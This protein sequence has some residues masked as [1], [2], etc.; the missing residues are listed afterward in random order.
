M[1]LPELTGLAAAGGTAGL[2][3]VRAVRQQRMCAD[4]RWKALMLPRR[5]DGDAVVS[6]LRSLSGLVSSPLIVIAGSGAVVL[7]VG[8]EDSEIIHRIAVPSAWEDSVLGQLRAAMPGVHI[9]ES[10][11]RPHVAA[12]V[13]LRRRGRAPLRDD[14]AETI[15]GGVLH[16]LSAVVGHGSHPV[17]D[18]SRAG[19]PARSGAGAS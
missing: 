14:D 3:G 12:A 10:A 17:D 4:M 19:R 11:P 2:L 16:A 7:E 1:L 6:A 5:V 8:V 13:E 15:A 18:C 9:G